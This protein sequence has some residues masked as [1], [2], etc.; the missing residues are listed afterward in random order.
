MV[1]EHVAGERLRLSLEGWG[2]LGEALA[3]HEGRE[4]LVL[5]GIPREEVVAEVIKGRGEYIAAQVV[6]V[7][8]P[9]PHRTAPPCPYVGTCTGC[10][11]QHVAYE[12]QLDIKRQMVMDALVG[13]GGFESSPVR[14]TVAAMEQYGYRNHARFTVG[15]RK[16]EPGFVNRV[17]RRFVAIDSCLIM[18]P[19]I[20]E[21]LAKL[22]GRC[23]ETSQLS[24][25]YGVNTGDFLVQPALKSPDVDLPTGQK[26]YRESLGGREF[27]IAASSF[28]QV[29]TSQAERMAELVRDGLQLSGEELL[30]DA[31]AGV[32]TFAILLAPY[33]K[34]V[35]AIEESASAVR[36]ALLNA[37]GLVG[38]RVLQGKAEEVLAQMEERPDGV[39]LDPPRTG[40]HRIT[41]DAVARLAP[42]R[43]VYVSCDPDTLAR[44]LRILCQAGFD[45]DWVQPIDMFPQTHHVECVAALSWKEHEPVTLTSRESQASA[46]ETKLVLASTSPRRRELL[47]S[48]GVEFQV[49]PPSVL[50]NMLGQESP[51]EMVERLALAKARSGARSVSSGLVVGADS[52][53]INDGLVLGKPADSAEAMNMLRSLR[54]KEHQVLTGVAIVDAA[55]GQAYVASQASTVTMREYTDPEI[56]AYVVS[57]APLDKAG[58]YAVQDRVFRPAA[59]LDGC[60]TNVMGLPLCL[61]RDMLNDAG[62]QFGPEAHI[63]VPEECSPCPL[64]NPTGP[65]GTGGPPWT[66]SA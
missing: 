60:Y 21:A 57:G 12:H 53:V 45:L 31:Y 34:E 1:Q 23:A 37:A 11:W 52:V 30:V 16:G 29:N 46:G 25:R 44:D 3:F 55:M 2:R 61:L 13:A 58:A 36:D 22:R 66:S 27:H 14:P 7:L 6:E 10:Q 18:H 40:C 26:H 17:S 20:N 43:V 41:L 24:L 56:E 38:V 62:L 59:S 51:Q 54:G 32:G 4:V 50:E 28:F 42:R 5:G 8:T 63:Q 9:S 65:E 15:R 33:A 48:L 39:I 49:I 47:G 35:I 64:R 19:W